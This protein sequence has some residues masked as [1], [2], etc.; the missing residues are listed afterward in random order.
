MAYDSVVNALLTQ[1]DGLEEMNNVIV[2][3]M[4]NRRELIDPAL[5]RPGRQ[6]RVWDV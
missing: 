2:F 4:T 6:A 3:G 5:L 1:M